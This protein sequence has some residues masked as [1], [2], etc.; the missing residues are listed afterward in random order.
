[1][2]TTTV[3]LRAPIEL[4]LVGPER[5]APREFR[6]FA[7]GVNESDQGSFLFDDEAATL[8]MAAFRARGR[9]LVIDYEHQSMAKP[10]IP[11]PAAGWMNLEV[12]AGA[13]WAVD[14]E[15]SPE[16]RDLIASRRYRYFSPSFSHER[17]EPRRI[18]EV[19]NAGLTNNPSLFGIDALVAASTAFRD[20]L[21]SNEGETAMATET[22]E[23]SYKSISW[24]R[25]A[26]GVATLSSGAVGTTDEETFTI[27]TG[28][29]AIVTLSGSELFNQMAHPTRSGAAALDRLEAYANGVGVYWAEAGA[30][31]LSWEQVVRLRNLGVPPEAFRAE[32]RSW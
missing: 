14:V 4:P 26:P 7:P 8:V 22:W 6:L 3:T 20:Y 16:A 1:M 32:Y 29:G 10:P 18:V 9:P 17:G 15:W 12:R 2:F 11:A 30:A 19:F 31:G 23:R 24:R 13:L 27:K 21:N 25:N 28:A 5:V